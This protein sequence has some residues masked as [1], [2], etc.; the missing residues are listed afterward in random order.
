MIPKSGYGF[1]EKIMLTNNLFRR[2]RAATRFLICLHGN[3]E[4][5]W[6]RPCSAARDEGDAHAR[7]DQELVA[8]H[9]ALAHGGRGAFHFLWFSYDLEHIV[10][11]RRLEELDRHR[12]HDEGKAR[13]LF[14]GL[15]EQG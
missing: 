7:F 14:L 8:A 10:H 15:L 5:L 4:R 11:A 9:D 1:L 12:A 3:A 6:N 13:R 2:K